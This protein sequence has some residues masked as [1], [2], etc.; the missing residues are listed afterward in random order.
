MLRRISPPSRPNQV[1]LTQDEYR[2]EYCSKT[3]VYRDLTE[4][5]RVVALGFYRKSIA[6]LKQRQLW[7]NISSTTHEPD[8]PLFWPT[9]PTF[10]HE[11][12]KLLRQIRVAKPDHIVPIS[13][14]C[15]CGFVIEV[16]S[17]VPLEDFGTWPVWHRLKD[18]EQRG[19]ALTSIRWPEY[20]SV[21]RNLAKG[22]AN[23]HQLSIAHNDLFSFNAMVT[24]EHSGVWVDLNSALPLSPTLR[25]IDIWT[26]LTYTVWGSLLRIQEW[27][28][29]VVFGLPHILSNHSLAEILPA[30][31]AHL[32]ATPDRTQALDST[33]RAELIRVY[34]SCRLNGRDDELG[35]VARQL[36]ATGL[37][38]HQRAYRESSLA[39][40]EH[41]RYLAAE[42]V[43]HRLVEREL[44]RTTL[45]HFQPRITELEQD[46]AA[47]RY[48]HSYWR[49][50][51]EKREH[52]IQ[53]LDQDIVTLDGQQAYWRDL[54]EKREHCIQKLDQDIV[55]LQEERSRWETEVQL[56]QLQFKFEA[57]SADYQT[58]SYEFSK[59]YS[60]RAWKV[61]RWVWRLRLALIPP[62]SLQALVLGAI[63]RRLRHLWLPRSVISDGAAL[64]SI[65]LTKDVF[66]T[67]NSSEDLDAVLIGQ[68]ARIRDHRREKDSM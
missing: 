56:K 2:I 63:H 17:G 22:I 35:D 13:A 61:V 3:C 31:I 15:D 33:A 67:D 55:A 39:A 1:E 14:V 6:A 18:P 46:I 66:D 58:L 25:A 44:Q 68:R 45:S 53:K 40:I 48:Q 37:L 26:F 49:D 51:A 60:S 23:L 50:L 20:L 29:N 4:T 9:K 16:I 36:T 54:A 12:A 42:R 41:E 62:G 27:Q 57:L 19:D 52:W 5:F 64:D 10:Q 43:R 32:M 8:Q 65:A 21:M 47:L 59:I 38:I 30:L 11:R 7:L 34:A 28:P 24:P